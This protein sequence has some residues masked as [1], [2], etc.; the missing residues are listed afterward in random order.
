[1]TDLETLA[2][3]VRETSERRSEV[4]AR[5]VLRTFQRRAVVG[6]VVLAA[7]LVGGQYSGFKQQ[8]NARKDRTAIANAQRQAIVDSGNAV[9]IAGCNQDFRDREATR[10]VLE[11][12]REQLRKNKNRIP[13]QDYNEAIAFY[14]DELDN[15]LPLPDC[16]AAGHILTTNPK[17][18]VA[19]ELPLY[20]GAPYAD[21]AP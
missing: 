16:R 13:A 9:A 4:V 19:P 3:Q 5:G 18:V 20:P 15:K 11:D 8:E 10:G 1:M 14:Q 17:K 21:S 12:A 2:E 6:F 7:G